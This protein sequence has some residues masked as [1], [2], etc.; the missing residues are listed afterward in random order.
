MQFISIGDSLHFARM[1]FM[2]I[3]SCLFL[4]ILFFAALG[5]SE[6][7]TEPYRW[8]EMQD[9]TYHA[10]RALGER[11]AVPNGYQRVHVNPGSFAEWLRGLPLQPK[12]KPLQ[13]YNGK[14]WRIQAAHHAKIDIE[15]GNKDLL[16]CADIIMR[17]WSE[18]LYGKEA[19]NAIQF[20]FANGERIDFAKWR[21][22]HRLRVVSNKVQWYP[23]ASADASYASYLNYME[24]IY[25]YA[26][27]ISMAKDMV[28]LSP[29]EKTEIGTVFLN[30]GSHAVIVVDKAVHKETGE[31][32]FLFA[33]GM[34]P[35][36]EIH[37]VKNLMDPDLSPWYGKQENGFLLPYDFRFK[38]GSRYRYQRPP[39]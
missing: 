25:R 10:E 27:T 24:W 2:Q 22:G 9:K 39:K 14:I 37:V 20:H 26:G 12:A 17:F 21:N 4:F 13:L 16:Q 35:A 7:T 5:Y 28:K 30:P 19:Y 6:P 1:Y 8:L 29:E 18:Y 32:I 36:M 31:P 33:Q 34:M 38:K 15:I 3:R 23:S 11:I